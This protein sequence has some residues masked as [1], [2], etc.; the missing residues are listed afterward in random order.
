MP[1]DVLAVLVPHVKFVDV[2]G[3]VHARVPRRLLPDRC[4]CLGP[5]PC[6][7]RLLAELAAVHPVSGWCGNCS[8]PAPCVKRWELLD[9]AVTP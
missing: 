9:K 5:W 6:R 8:I 1:T 3:L 2:N 4:T 7:D